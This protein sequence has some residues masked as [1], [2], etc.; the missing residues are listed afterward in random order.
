MPE[1]ELDNFEEELPLISFAKILAL[2]KH[3]SDLNARRATLAYL[4]IKKVR[5]YSSKG[6]GP[7]HLGIASASKRELEEICKNEEGKRY[8]INSLLVHHFKSIYEE[9]GDVETI[10]DSGSNQQILDDGHKGA[11]R[12]IASGS[13]LSLIEALNEYEQ[14]SGSDKKAMFLFRH[15]IKKPEY[16]EIKIPYSKERVGDLWREFKPVS[17]LWASYLFEPLSTGSQTFENDFLHFL[18][19]AERFRCFAETYS[20]KHRSGKLAKQNEMW[21]LPP[22]IALPKCSYSTRT[23]TDEEIVLLERY[24]SDGYND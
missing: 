19:V 14:G 3:P 2:M 6:K 23:L 8:A 5:H 15:T 17:H 16:S 21:R 4:A 12:G 9:N 18:A 7:I 11:I 24:R 10:I 1:I 13:I 20:P 22:N